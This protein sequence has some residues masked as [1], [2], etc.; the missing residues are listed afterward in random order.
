MFTTDKTELISTILS[1]V[2]I[3]AQWIAAFFMDAKPSYMVGGVSIFMP[4][5]KSFGSSF[6][7]GSFLKLFHDVLVFIAPILLRRIINYAEPACDGTTSGEIVNLMSQDCQ[8]IGDL[9]PYLN[10]LWSSPVQISIAIYMLYEILGASVFA[11]LVVMF[12]LIPVNEYNTFKLKQKT[13]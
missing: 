6:L 10:M 7:C 9:I 3:T 2:I 12:V 13:P 5:I 4:L 1:F 8:N 11:G